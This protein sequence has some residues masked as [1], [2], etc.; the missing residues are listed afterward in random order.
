MKQFFKILMSA[1]LALPFSSCEVEYDPIVILPDVAL[2]DSGMTTV[3]TV[4]IYQND[5]YTVTLTRTEGLSKA[6]EFD[7]VVDQTLI[8]EYNELNGTS[9][10]MMPESGY[11]IGAASIAFP[12]KA[13]EATFTIQFKPETIV[14]EAGS[15]RQAENYV[16]PFACVPK[17]TVN[18]EVQRLSALV[19][20]SFSEPTV[21]VD[22]PVDP[23][24][25]TFIAGVP[26]SRKLELSCRTNFTTLKP[27]KLA[28]A[29]TQE[30][31]D[32]YNDANGSEYLLLPSSCYTI[33]AGSFDSEALSLVY[34]ITLDASEVDPD[35]AYL[36]PLKLASSDYTIVQDNIYYVKVTVQEIQFS[37]SNTDRYEAATRL[38]HEIKI[39]VKLN[40][41]LADDV[42]VEFAYDASKIAA[43]N[44]S[45][46]KTYE[47]LDAS[48][49][50]VTNATMAAGAVKTSATVTVDMTDVAFDD[51]KEYVLPFVL[52]QTKLPQGSVMQS[53]DVVYV[54]LKRTLYG[55]WSN[56]DSNDY[57]QKTGTSGWSGSNYM[58]ATTNP[59]DTNVDGTAYPYANYYFS[60]SRGYHWYVAW[61]EIY[62]GDQNKRVVHCFSGVTSGYTQQ[63]Q[64]AQTM[65]YGSY[66]DMETG[67]VFF[68][69]QYYWNDDDKANDKRMTI[70]CYLE[71]PL[72]VEE[73]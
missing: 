55:S 15:T 19:R 20:F 57:L 21:T 30:M 43:Y 22:A 61:D 60:W 62:N 26:V 23:E 72:T 3:P 33:D 28:F 64:V 6:A 68:D 35:H 17:T 73:F 4:S 39:D 71:S 8:D 66:F 38:A 51:G 11:T 31:V 69:F 65:D 52:D 13:K 56:R 37:I 41:A 58:K 49:I 53:D 36:L 45:K 10:G 27:A 12:E 24:E 32:A 1:A 63:Q 46:G 40:G 14:A 48:K 5:A 25:L 54:R 50:A 59:S 47:A 44:E 18:S 42:P 2:E 29:A 16:I 7:I 34:G 70:K 67:T 9:F